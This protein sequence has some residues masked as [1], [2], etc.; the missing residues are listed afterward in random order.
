MTA[1]RA[2]PDDR[3]RLDVATRPHVAV[4]EPDT[5]MRAA[6]LLVQVHD[7]LRQELGRLVE[8][9]QEV[10]AG[11]LDAADA[12]SLLNE[13]TMRQ[14]SWQLGSFCAAYCR[15]VAIHHTIED[16]RLFPDLAAREPALL[17]VVE[18]LESEHAVVAEVLD[19]LDRALVAMVA[20]AARIDVVEREI[21]ELSDVLLSHL[22]YEERELVEPIERLGV[23]V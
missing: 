13:L 18:R 12:R 6:S 4:A 23:L 2:G 3:R 21:A 5:A 1:G 11:R 9:V 7:H 10:A 15:V 14:N 20:D 8:A 22:A 17:P 16:R 19:R